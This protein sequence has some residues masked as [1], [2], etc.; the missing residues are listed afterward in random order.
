MN[1]IIFSDLNRDKI[2]SKICDFLNIEKPTTELTNLKETIK[3]ICVAR[4]CRAVGLTGKYNY[5]SEFFE[6]FSCIMGEAVCE[7]LSIQTHLACDELRL[8]KYE[9]INLVNQIKS[10]LDNESVEEAFLDAFELLDKF[11]YLIPKLKKA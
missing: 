5:K 6:F 1:R 3:Q 11:K 4:L 2:T 8:V 10:Y 9:H 7:K